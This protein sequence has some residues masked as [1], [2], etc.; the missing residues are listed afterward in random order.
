MLNSKRFPFM[1]QSI[2]QLTIKPVV[3]TYG[4][5]EK[6]ERKKEECVCVLSVARSVNAWRSVAT[7]GVAN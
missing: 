4:P 5:L 6:L 7:P 2:A 1:R 3:L